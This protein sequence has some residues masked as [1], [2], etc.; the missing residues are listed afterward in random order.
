MEDIKTDDLKDQ[1]GPGKL[2]VLLDWGTNKTF[3]EMFWTMVQDFIDVEMDRGH[4]A[5]ADT[6]KS[7]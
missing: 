6:I 7:N 1:I 3:D 4:I 5:P 2:Q